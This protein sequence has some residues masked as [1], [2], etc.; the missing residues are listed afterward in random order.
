MAAK[1]IIL[2]TGGTGLLG[3]GM[4]E[5]IQNNFEIISIHQRPYIIQGS[6]I[7]HFSLDIRDKQAVDDLFSKYRFDAVIHA[8]GI[9]SV[10]YV[11]NNYA[12]SL[13][14]NIVGT[15]NI[16]SACRRSKTYLVYISTNAVFDGNNAPYREFDRV[17]PINK[18]GRLKVEC[19]RL[20]TETLEH[21]CIVRPILMYGWN[22]PHC[23]PNVATW[24]YD[25]LLNGESL[26]L[27][28]DIYENPLFNIQCG[29]ALWEVVQKRPSGIFHIAGKDIVNRYEFGK[30]IAATFGLDDS[31]LNSVKSSYFP[32]IAPRPSNTSFITNR[33]ED[34]LGIKA[35]SLEEGLLEMRALMVRK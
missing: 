2:I 15:L 14:S 33:M 11:E 20:V 16:T 12:E 1:K 34:E 35:L 5:T 7:T 13:E 6:K 27:V 23:R 26:S 30:Q 9:A 28:N 18:Y 3:R 25:K 19:E 24:I 21:F 17:A 29:R 22:H 31:L 8:A 32:H 10:D 4:E